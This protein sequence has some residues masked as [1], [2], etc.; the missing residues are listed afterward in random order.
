MRHRRHHPA[1]RESEVKFHRGVSSRGHWKDTTAWRGSEGEQ[2]YA[3]VLEYTLQLSRLATPWRESPPPCQKNES[4]T[5]P[6]ARHVGEVR[7]KTHRLHCRR[8]S[9]VIDVCVCQGCLATALDED[10][11]ALRGTRA[12]SASIALEETAEGDG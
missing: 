11:T 9:V 8:S 6:R 7:G 10:A 4:I 3:A 2:T 1:S 12:R 5:F